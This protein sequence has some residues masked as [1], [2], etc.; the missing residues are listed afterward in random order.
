MKHARYNLQT[1]LD[2]VIDLLEQN[3]M[4]V[5][6][7]LEVS[8]VPQPLDRHAQDVRRA[9]QERD[10]AF[11]EFTL[12]TAVDLQHAVWRAI[13]LKDDIHRA[14]NAVLD[15]KLRCPEALFVFEMIGDDRPAG[16]QGE[17]R[18]RFEFGAD[19]RDPDNAHIP[20][21][22]RADQKAIFRRDVLQ[23]LAVFGLHPF[24]SETC[25]LIQQLEKRHAL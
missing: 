6:R 22:A 7:G 9:L 3:L 20:T 2:P 16:A 12:G 21:D 17:S 10:I 23:D 4:A 1:V 8:L 15:E 19:P 13:A 25:R 14:P 5:Q 11:A 24:R 18:R